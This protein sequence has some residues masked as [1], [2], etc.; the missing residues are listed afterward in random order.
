VCR[1][2]KLSQTGNL[3]PILR[4]PDLDATRPFLE[5]DI[6]AAIQSLQSS[7]ATV[8][9][10]SDTLSRQCDLL[11]KQLRQ[12]Q[13]LDDDRAKDIARLRKKH[14]AGRQNTAIAVRAHYTVCQRFAG[15]FTKACAE[16][17][18]PTRAVQ[19]LSVYFTG[20]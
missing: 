6:R 9:K 12:Q 7:T 15:T 4:E 19:M 11:R 1:Y 14:E 10:Q 2:N 5:T 20:Q 16:T 13:R 8:Q 18:L 17:R 3:H